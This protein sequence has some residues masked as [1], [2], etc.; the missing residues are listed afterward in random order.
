MLKLYYLIIKHVYIFITF[1]MFFYSPHLFH[2]MNYFPL[3]L[4]DCHLATRLLTKTNPHRFR[5]PFTRWRCSNHHMICSCF[6]WFDFCES[7]WWVSLFARAPN[8]KRKSCVGVVFFWVFVWW[9]RRLSERRSTFCANIVSPNEPNCQT[10]F[11]PHFGVHDVVY[12]HRCTVQL[13]HT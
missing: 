3:P 2:S 9:F 13:T 5:L 11:R 6:A 1:M 4:A 12:Q 8:A 10:P 7:V